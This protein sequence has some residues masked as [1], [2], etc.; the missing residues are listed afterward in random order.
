MKTDPKDLFVRAY[1]LSGEARETYLQEACGEDAELRLEVQRL[2]VKAEKFDSF[3]RDDERA[4]IAAD[5]FDATFTEAEGDEIGPR[6]ICLHRLPV[7]KHRIG[8]LKH[9]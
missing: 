9:L 4:T 6:Q 7:D 5:A 3:I 8:R 2:L 1:E